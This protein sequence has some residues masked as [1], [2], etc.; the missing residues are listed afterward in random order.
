MGARSA[1][2]SGGNV[3]RTLVEHW[4]GTAWKVH[5][6]PA[7]GYNSVLIGVAATS[8]TNAWAV[9]GLGTTRPFKT[10]I[11]HWNGTAWKIQKSPNLKDLRDGSP[12]ELLLGVA[13]TSSRNAWA[14]GRYDRYRRDRTLALHWN[15]TTWGP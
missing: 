11:E 3:G 14:V 1:L 6:S 2:G 7:P 5:K 10:L 12:E 9:G 13:A 4:N 15:G 8:A